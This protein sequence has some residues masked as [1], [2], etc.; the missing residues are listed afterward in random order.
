MGVSSNTLGRRMFVSDA[1]E[2]AQYAL[3]QRK[4]GEKSRW[5]WIKRE[6][7]RQRDRW[8]KSVLNP[9]NLKCFFMSERAQ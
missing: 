1:T 6:R 2:A 8:R 7:E 5:M 9:K 3:L 4:E